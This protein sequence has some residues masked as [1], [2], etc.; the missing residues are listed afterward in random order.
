MR[1]VAT[2]AYGAWLCRLSPWIKFGIRY[3]R[4]RTIR[5]MI[6]PAFGFM[7]LPLGYA[8]NFQGLVIVIGATLGPV[9]VVSFSTLRTFTRL[10]TQLIGVVKNALWPELSRAFGAGQIALARQ[11]H[12]H[13][14]QV[15][16]AL[17]IGGGAVLWVVGPFIYRL[18]IRHG[19]AFDATCFHVLLL[20]IVTNSFWD[21]S[22]VIPM[23]INAH[24]RIAVTYSIAAGVSLALAW[25]LTPILGLVGAAVA[26]IAMDGWMT[27]VVLKAS[28]H[29]V[30]DDFRDFV[31]ALFEI[32]RFRRQTLEVAPEI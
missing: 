23:S 18:W 26:L 24:C 2:I 6:A 30:Q 8:L 9:A 16:L 28:L 19:V 15:A 27:F 20:V 31:V 4:L 14:C 11:L 12:R 32:P 3:S 22:S 7:A 25:I 13:A 21:T 29:Y 1:T 5:R 10:N 17:S